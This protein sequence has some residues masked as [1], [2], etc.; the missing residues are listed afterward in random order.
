MDEV[1]KGGSAVVT[2]GEG[3]FLHPADGADAG[4][5]PAG[6]FAGDLGQAVIDGGDSDGGY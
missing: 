2:P 4:C 1:A 3:W 6:E 5:A